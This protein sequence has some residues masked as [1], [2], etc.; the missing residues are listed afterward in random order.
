MR[1]P[2]HDAVAAALRT[3]Y[4]QPHPG[5][6][7][8]T[9]ERRF[10]V[11]RRNV[12]AATYPAVLLR[13]VSPAD[14]PALL[15][16]VRSYFA[17]SRRAARIMIENREADAA[18]GP[19]LQAAGLELDERTSFLT[20]VGP[21]PAAADLPGLSIEPVADDGLREFEDT[22]VRGFANA[23]GPR[24]PEDLDWRVDLRRAE[25]AG[26]ARYWLAR[27]DGE[28]AGALSWY[29]RRDRLIF[30]LA[31][32]VP[33]RNRGIARHL[34]CRLLSESQREGARSVV[35][36]ADEA[37]TPIDLYRRLGFTD[38]VYWRATYE[39]DVGA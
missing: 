18:L 37:D 17:G 32:R 36:N 6:G 20:H 35:I 39:L 3:A 13:D 26:G 11:Y 8:A 31:T 30:S 14:A 25:M 33:Y 34:L 15:A 1:H 12:K 5:M 27:I 4:A 38:E 23:D 10:G 7:W 19:A 28:A 24:P 22:R 29:D 16:D 2:H 21:A 9:E